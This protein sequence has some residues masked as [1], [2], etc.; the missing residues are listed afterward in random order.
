[1]LK[2]KTKILSVLLLSLGIIFVTP[3]K[4]S[5]VSESIPKP[6]EHLFV[7][8]MKNFHEA[9]IAPTLKFVKNHFNNAREFI[10]KKFTKETPTSHVVP[11]GKNIMHE[12]K[13]VETQPF[14]TIGEGKFQKKEVRQQAPWEKEPLLV[15]SMKDLPTTKVLPSE[16]VIEKTEMLP[17]KIKDVKVLQQSGENWPYTGEIFETP[18]LTHEQLKREQNTSCAYH[19]LYNAEVTLNTTLTE[20]KRNDAYRSLERYVDSSLPLVKVIYEKRKSEL[21]KELK[22]LGKIDKTRNDIPVEELFTKL[23]EYKKEG[24]FFAKEKRLAI[25]KKLQEL[26]K[27]VEDNISY[28]KLLEN[29][30]EYVKDLSP[31]EEKELSDL[32]NKEAKVLRGSFLLWINHDGSI[33]TNNLHEGE[34]KKLMEER[35][36]LRDNKDKIMML[37]PA[38]IESPET[39]IAR[40][41]NEFQR[42]KDGV[43]IVAWTEPGFDHWVSYAFHKVNGKVTIE[44]FNSAEKT[45]K[46]QKAQPMLELF[47]THKPIVVT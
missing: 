13:G 17:T 43:M 32:F 5:G 40:K 24:E 11:F 7:R 25:I 30:L 23:L 3:E 31:K 6:K 42:K 28:Y 14:P 36:E 35:P 47:F 33:N 37:T 20:Q 26:G 1:M 22:R 9:I 2:R 8:T 21:I 38:D 18:G 16:M 44:Y 29:Y 39:E 12:G 41:I 10:R 34:I 45:K 27:Q 4:V 19:V 15:G 46:P